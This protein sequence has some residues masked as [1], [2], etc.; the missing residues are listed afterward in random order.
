MHQVNDTILYKFIAKDSSGSLCS[1]CIVRN[2]CRE[3]SFFFLY[4]QHSIQS[5]EKLFIHKN[6]LLSWGIGYA[7]Y[8]V[9]VA[10]FERIY[11]RTVSNAGHLGSSV[12][13]PLVNAA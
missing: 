5:S 4:R 11:R 3:A 8:I 6:F 7:V 1:C 13:K 9:D 12:N 2:D 10:A